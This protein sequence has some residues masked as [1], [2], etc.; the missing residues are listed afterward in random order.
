M[1]RNYVE[2]AKRYLDDVLAGREPACKWVKA[3]CKRQREDLK[4]QRSKAWTY[5][6][7]D[8]H[9]PPQRLGL[10]EVPVSVIAVRA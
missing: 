5:A 6:R 8:G 10:A 2:I 9:G 1:T 7:G 3:A 4:R